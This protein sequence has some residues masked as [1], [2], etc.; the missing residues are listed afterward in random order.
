MVKDIWIKIEGVPSVRCLIDPFTE[1]DALASQMS[2]MS[3]RK[4]SLTMVYNKTI[5]PVG[6]AVEKCGVRNG[7]T[8]VC[9][10]EYLNLK[11]LGIID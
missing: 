11:E 7:D 9:W 6:S 1:V 10:D 5:L 3:G 2:S 4:A 8:I